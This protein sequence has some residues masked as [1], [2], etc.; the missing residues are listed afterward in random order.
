MPRAP[1]RGRLGRT[2]RPGAGGRHVGKRDPDAVIYAAH[3]QLTRFS[4]DRLHGRPIDGTESGRSPTW[5]LAVTPRIR[6]PAAEPPAAVADS[7]ARICPMGSGM[8]R[9]GG[10]PNAARMRST[11]S[12]EAG[13]GH[14]PNTLPAGRLGGISRR[15]GNLELHGRPEA[16]LAV[17]G[18]AKPQVPEALPQPRRRDLVQQRPAEERGGGDAGRNH[19]PREVRLAATAAIAFI[20]RRPSLRLPGRH[21]RRRSRSSQSR[22][23]LMPD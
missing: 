19:L 14:P 18:P 3:K 11:V 9:A 4:W 7:S 6:C 16:L 1:T 23:R 13:R 10:R 8:A 5:R 2:L 20:S 17:R 21:C 22:S 12:S 15:V